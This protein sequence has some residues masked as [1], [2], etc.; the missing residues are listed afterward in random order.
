MIP[1]EILAALALTAIL[2]AV[3]V[4]GRAAW[5]AV[6]RHPITEHREG[7]VARRVERDGSTGVPP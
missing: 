3:A 4:A 6:H 2:A 7:G 1:P 5:Q